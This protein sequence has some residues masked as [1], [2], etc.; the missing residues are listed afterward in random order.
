MSADLRRLREWLTFDQA[1]H[2]LTRRSGQRMG[3]PELLRLA[4]DGHAALCVS[5]PPVEVHAPG[6]GESHFIVSGSRPRPR[7]IEGVWDLPAEGLARQH[8]HQLLRDNTGGTGPL[9][10][11]IR[12]GLVVERGTTRWEIP[13]RVWPDHTT[14]GRALAVRWAVLDALVV[15]QHGLDTRADARE[16][17]LSP[18]PPVPA[19]EAWAKTAKGRQTRINEFLQTLKESGVLKDLDRIHPKAGERS[20]KANERVIWEAAG[21]A[22]RAAPPVT[23]GP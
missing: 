8:L 5:L 3:W 9:M 23:P 15:T 11:E 4:L 18:A 14:T 6:A 1:T 16:A 2:D 22:T 21:H 12:T 7:S 17:A 10:A 13:Q 20:L 19:D